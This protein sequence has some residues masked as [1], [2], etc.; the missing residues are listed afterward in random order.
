MARIAGRSPPRPHWARLFLPFAFGYFLSYFFRTANAVVAEDLARDIGAD[1]AALGLLTGAYMIGFAAMQLPVGILLDRYGPRRVQT[2]LLSAAAL[3]ALGFALADG[4]LGLALARGLI[5]AGVAACLMS[6]FKN[7]ALWFAR[8]RLPVVNNLT[9]VAG[10]LGAF[11]AT[12]PMAA[13]AGALGWRGAFAALAA[14][15]LLGA[16]FVHL[17][18]SEPPAARA[19]ESLAEQIA[20]T[21]AIFRDRFFWRVA[22]V[23]FAV[24]AIHAA[25]ISLWA[26]PWLHD[27][28]GLD[29]AGVATHLQV[30]PLAMI[31]GYLAT[32]FLA[33]RLPARGISALAL[34][35]VAVGLFLVNGALMLVPALDSPYLQWAAFGFLA[36]ASVLPY[37]ILAQAYPAALSGRVT[38]ALNLLTFIA[39]FAAQWLIGIAIDAA[40]HRAALALALLPCVAAWLWLLR[41]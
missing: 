20:G 30:I 17:A 22:P 28:A 27:L 6:A 16:L 29:R 39:A 35:A 36:T 5:G 12:T 24:Q 25:Y 34:V 14:V 2:A 10:T 38:T 8:E 13:L 7:N 11:A 26:G 32:G 21:A 18:A 15:T 31:A 41:R 4:I 23:A 1:A 3:G 33:A 19:G 9:L 40:G 37:S